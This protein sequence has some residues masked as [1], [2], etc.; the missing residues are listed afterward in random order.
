MSKVK[1][2]QEGDKRGEDYEEEDYDVINTANQ[3]TMTSVL[4]NHNSFLRPSVNI[5][6]NPTVNYDDINPVD[7]NSTI[8]EDLESSIVSARNDNDIELEE[9]SQ[10]YVENNSNDNVTP[11]V[12]DI[13]FPTSVA[14]DNK[15]ANRNHVLPDSIIK[16]YKIIIYKLIDLRNIILNEKKLPPSKNGRIIPVALDKDS[17]VFSDSLHT[18]GYLLID[19][20]RQPHKKPYIDNV[21][22]S[23]RYTIYSFLPLQLYAQ[24]SKL[25]NIY[26]FIIAILQM[27][28]GWS[29]TGT[30]TTIIPICIFMGI[31]M[32]REVWDD[33]RRHKLDKQENNKLTKILYKGNQFQERGLIS[34]KN[35]ILSKKARK[36]FRHMDRNEHALL[37]LNL[38]NSTQSMPSMD[39]QKKEAQEQKQHEKNLL[40]HT[41]SN[42]LSNT[43]DEFT[44]L[45]L[46]R[47][48]HDIHLHKTEWKNLRVGDFIYLNQDDWVPADILL[49]ASDGEH[50]EVFV[51]TMALDGET[52]LKTKFPHLELAKSMQTATGLVN[53]AAKV[54]VEDPNNDLYNFEGNIELLDNVTGTWNKY[55]IN[56]DNVVYRG[57]VLRNTNNVIGMVIYTGEETK[58]RMNA[59]KNPRIKAPKLQ[60]AIN[61]I[62]I[63]MV[64]V[65]ASMSLFS[66]LGEKVNKKKYI[67]NNK[68]QY[69]LKDDAGSAPTVMGFI[70]MYN[71]LIPLSLYVTMEI[72]K[73]MQS[74]LMEWDIDMYY[75]PSDVSCESRTATILEELGQVSYVFSDKTGTLTDNLMIFRKFTVC[76]TSWVHDLE[77]RYIADVTEDEDY[78]LNKEDSHI[79]NSASSNNVSSEHLE[80]TTIRKSIG[81][82]SIEYKSNSSI[83]YT[84]RPS[85]ASLICKSRNKT[86]QNQEANKAEHDTDDIIDV[87]NVNKVPGAKKLNTGNLQESTLEITDSHEDSQIS[88]ALESAKTNIQDANKNLLTRNR[89]H[90]SE[91]KS[92]VE[93][94]MYIQKNPHTYFAQRA[95]FFILS[96]ALCHTCVPKKIRGS[97]PLEKKMSAENANKL[98]SSSDDDNESIEYQAASP[99]ELALIGAA[100]DMGYVVINKNG[101]ILSIRTYP[102]G[103]DSPSVVEDYEVLNVIEF[104][105]VRKRMTVI[106]RLKKEPTRV[107]LICK[108]A[109]NV[110]LERLYNNA[111]ALEKTQEI[112]RAAEERRKDEAEV[113]LEQRR[114]LEQ[115][116]G[117]RSSKSIDFIASRPSLS[118]QAVRESLSRHNYGR[119]SNMHHRRSKSN[120]RPISSTFNEASMSSA[121]FKKNCD[122]D[123]H[124]NFE[125]DAADHITSINDFLYNV[126]RNKKEVEAVG[127][128]SRD[129]LNKQITEK[130]QQRHSLSTTSRNQPSGSSNGTIAHS[131]GSSSAQY[132]SPSLKKTPIE[133]LTAFT[134]KE[135]GYNEA[136]INAGDDVGTIEDYI[137]D[138][139]LLRDEEYVIEKTLQA[140]DEFSTQGLRTLLYSY[141][142]IK[143]EEYQLWAKRYHE[144]KI[145]LVDRAKKMDTVGEEI[146]SNLI[147]LG[148]TAIED[149]LQDGVPEAIEKLRRAGIKMWMLTGDKRETAINI[150]YSCNLIHD[151]STVVILSHDDENLLAKISAV[152]QEIETGNV[153]HCAV[154]IDGSTL[155]IFETNSTMMGVFIDLCTKTDVVICC[156]A[157]PSQKALMVSSIRNTNKKLV[158]L[159]IGDGANDIAMIQSADIGVG[160]AG[161]EGLQA[162]RS[163]DY[164]IGQFRF[165]LKLLFVHGRYNYSRTS[166]FV[167]CTFFKE[168]LFYMTQ[169]IFQRYTMFSG[170]SLYES[171]SLSMFN[172]LF[173]SLPVLCIGMFEKDLKPQTLLAVPELYT[174]GRLSQGFN[175]FIFVQWMLLA[176]GSSVLITFMNIYLWGFTSQSDSTLYPLGFMNFTVVVFIVNFKCQFLE[177]R[178][179]SSIAFASVI[180]SCGGWLIWCCFLPVVYSDDFMYDVLGGFYQRFG[181]DISFWASILL[182]CV[183]PLLLSMLGKVFQTIFFPSDSDIFA[184]LE[185]EDE[186]RKKIEMN[187]F[188]EMKQGW[189][190][191]KDESTVSKYTGKFVNR[192]IKANG[193]TTRKDDSS[194]GLVYG[195]NTNA[196]VN[197]NSSS[198]CE[199]KGSSSTL[200][201][202]LFDEN[203]YEMLPSGKLIKRKKAKVLDTTKKN[204]IIKETQKLKKVIKKKLRF[205]LKD[206]EDVDAIIQKRLDDLE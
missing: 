148:A 135:T 140:I 25:A 123:E 54:T 39:I 56:T 84:G 113:F 6:R 64:L 13:V 99:D 152:S 197:N 10:N 186:V 73:I 178:N 155:G 62:V 19:E 149:K 82:A 116:L 174:F 188:S 118:L 47:S 3:I 75:E 198:N 166:K 129:S 128:K 106:V 110:I 14:L 29:T 101:N 131:N 136:F 147:L 175:L 137:G 164:S 120:N 138:E 4:D 31:S 195:D 85:I 127:V 97:E 52:N 153:A 193:D 173:T 70:I 5:A 46:L 8:S 145:S 203:K 28:P 67:I 161:K 91:L 38:K 150:G 187:A 119:S 63:F 154:V 7:V 192:V 92:S 80:R 23:S 65:V 124:F 133:T 90:T 117:T 49:I 134:N 41:N 59:I 205:K 201:S 144:A 163:S 51:E 183:C 143:E 141:K 108:G 104:N 171:W 132:S 121:V 45:N 190:W 122:E 125:D 55:P 112:N 86:L 202:S 182:I 158:T 88:P 191:D 151:Y 58:I 76:G 146:E 48:R 196:A 18:D 43:A 139:A 11:A 102:E 184:Q 69:L 162:S 60:T 179:R 180:I 77:S 109:D 40:S 16:W 93:L 27:I 177:M 57:S 105:S 15:T 95:K 165:L 114:S 206:N 168:T 126:D 72:I 204:S 22:T 83:K 42:S 37:K 107:L 74:K 44:N 96:L 199:L 36:L 103:F 94:I 167:L 24:F 32:A 169:M 30:F 98:A 181:R 81:R 1:V 185:Q 130:Y 87:G 17:K 170:T 71:T 115:R 20:R 111:L 53:T 89:D 189:T 34:H 61:Y 12:G 9:Y 21:I 79:D 50:S 78:K 176:A 33:F 172:T 2:T 159:A 157:S 194:P 160:I 200:N 66:F 26:F 100:R 156:R 35:N 68:Y 142:W